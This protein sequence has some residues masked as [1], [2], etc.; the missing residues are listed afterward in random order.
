MA[1]FFG[2]DNVRN[3]QFGRVIISGV[4]LHERRLECVFRAWEVDVD[5]VV[6]V[7]HGYFDH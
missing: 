5:Q 3:E 4:Y 6:V 7:S 2:E 1:E